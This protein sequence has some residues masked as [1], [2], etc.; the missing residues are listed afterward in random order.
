MFQSGRGAS[1]SKAGSDGTRGTQSQRREEGIWQR[2]AAHKRSRLAA[3][4]ESASPWDAHGMVRRDCFDPSRSCAFQN[5]PELT[6]TDRRRRPAW[7]APRSGSASAGPKEHAERSFNTNTVPSSR[8]R[9]EG[10]TLRSRSVTGSRH[11]QAGE[12]IAPASKVA[13]A[14]RPVTRN[15]PT[16]TRQSAIPCNNAMAHCAS[17]TGNEP[18]VKTMQA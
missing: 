17:G 12:H 15:F 3:Q 7:L 9:P 4:H 16:A 11:R 18:A 2:G 5:H 8:R 6:Q 10:A 14:G 13:L 1:A